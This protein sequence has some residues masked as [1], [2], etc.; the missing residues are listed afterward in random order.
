[1]TK[2]TNKGFTFRFNFALSLKLV[3][4]LIL[5]SKKSTNLNLVVTSDKTVYGCR[6]LFYLCFQIRIE[7][8]WT[9]IKKKKLLVH[10]ER[11]ENLK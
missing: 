7:F 9:K 5:I 2:K 10:F 8:Q 4:D 1:M 6:R 3:G 11:N